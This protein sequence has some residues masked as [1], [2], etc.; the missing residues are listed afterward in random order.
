MTSGQSDRN[1]NSVEPGLPNTF[2]MPKARSRSNVACLTVRDLALVLA[3]LRDDI[4]SPHG[5]LSTRHCEERSDEAIHVSACRAMD[6]FASLAMTIYHV[7]VLFMVGWPS[8]LAVQ[9]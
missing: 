3:G 9:I 7:A 6:C 1:G 5:Q 4:R 8:A 2:L